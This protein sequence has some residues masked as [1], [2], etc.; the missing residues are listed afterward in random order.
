MFPTDYLKFIMWLAKWSSYF[1]KIYEICS[2]WSNMI[3]ELHVLVFLIF[4]F[5]WYLF[6][7][8]FANNC[9][10]VERQIYLTSCLIQLSLLWKFCCR[11]F[12]WIQFVANQ[13]T[14]WNYFGSK[15]IFQV[16][17]VQWW[18]NDTRGSGFESSHRQVLPTLY[19]RGMNDSLEKVF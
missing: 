1:F 6:E 19:L 12:V 16:V 14:P 17:V 18:Q 9:L 4:Y 8:I 5:L 10:F 13:E 2:R 7:L 3:P 11:W 15:I